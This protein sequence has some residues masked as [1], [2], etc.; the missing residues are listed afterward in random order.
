MILVLHFE[1]IIDPSKSEGIPAVRSATI[2]A[3]S[4]ISVAGAN[5]AATIEGYQA[6][7]GGTPRHLTKLIP[8]GGNSR[9]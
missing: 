5:R 4:P 3:P 9:F 1:T 8:A 6:K 2:C 7:P